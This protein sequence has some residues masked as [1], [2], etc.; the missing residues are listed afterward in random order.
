VDEVGD[1]NASCPASGLRLGDDASFEPGEAPP[2]PKV[3][4]A[5]IDDGE[6]A[7]RAEAV[8]AGP[9]LPRV[10]YREAAPRAREPVS[11]HAEV[12]LGGSGWTSSGF[13]GRGVA[14][15]DLALR[16]V[17]LARWATVEV[18]ARAE[19]WLPD[20]AGLGEG[21]ATRLYVWQAQLNALLPWATFSA[22]RLR[23]FGV[24]GTTV[25]DGA[26]ASF[27]VGPARL[28]LFG[29]AVPAPD[30]LAPGTERATA[31]GSWSVA[32]T[33]PGEMRLASDGRIAMVRSPELGTRYEASLGGRAWVKAVDVSAEVHLGTGGD[34]QAPGSLDAA[35]IDLVARP[36]LGFTLGG[37]YRH[38]ALEWPDRFV[39]PAAYPGRN[40]AA[41]GFVSWDAWRYLRIAITGGTSRDQDSG[42]ERAWA[43]PELSATRLVGG[44][45]DVVAGYLEERGWLDGR[46]AYAQISYRPGER[47]RVV[48]RGTWSY[49]ESLGLYRDEVGAY[50]G[51]D[52]GLGRHLSLRVSALGRMALVASETGPPYGIGANGALVATY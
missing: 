12:A 25:V 2:A 15:V 17:P 13:P 6:L 31:G 24:L 8:A 16:A 33:G 39:E 4:P 38:A 30:T 34:V 19:R 50:L 21:G 3:L 48:A 26:A 22:G 18:D 42:L 27:P 7:R 51:V 40:D 36:G 43:G 37:G 1:H 20:A 49:E 41:D 14:R 11:R 46:S 28:G 52:A 29:G 44:R 23:T 35:R 32:G 5:P 47:Y 10:V 45:L 9:L